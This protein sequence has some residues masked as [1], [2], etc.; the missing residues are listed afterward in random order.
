M[1]LRLFF[2]LVAL[3]LVVWLLKP[4]VVW[5]EV[6]RLYSQRN[7]VWGVLAAAVGVYML[8]GLYTLFRQGW[9][10]Q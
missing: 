9:P 4:S 6:K 3:I 5:A 8:F 10:L 7:Y 2:L 1:K